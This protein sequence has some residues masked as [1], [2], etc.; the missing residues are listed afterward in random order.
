MDET[1][2]PVELLLSVTRDGRR[3]LGSQIEDQLRRGIRDGSLRPGARVPSTRDLARQLGISRRVAV[4]A[5]AQLAAEGYLTLRQGARPRVSDAAT[6]AERAPSG[7][8]RRAPR[9]RFDFRP[10][11]PDV[12]T[13]PRAAWLRSLREAVATITDAELSYGDPRGVVSLRCALADYLGRVRGVVADPEQIVITNGY[14]QGL[15]LVCHAL[16]AAGATRIAFDEP[17]NPEDAL[18]AVRA[19]L[20]PVAIGVDEHGTRVDE[21]GRAEADA[22]VLTPAHQHPTGVVLSGERGQPCCHGCATAKRSQS[23]TTTTPSTA[24]TAPRLEPFRASI[25]IE[26]CTQ[27]QRVKRS[28][29]RSGSAGW[30][31]PPASLTRLA[32]RRSLPTGAPPGSN[33]A[34]SPTS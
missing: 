25:Q 7:P 18:V 1:S 11:V 28:R 19:G 4:D 33:S 22:V 8:A 15:G 21:L 9:V 30:W 34:R 31:S 32:Q 3:T 23:R 14:T 12:S 29:R 26:W 2:Q 5:Y 10:S 27:D 16:A 13:F 6:V 17:S 20:Q 24:T